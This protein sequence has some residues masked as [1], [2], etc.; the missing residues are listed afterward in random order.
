MQKVGMS[1]KEIKTSIRSQIIKVFFLPL[2]TACIHLTVA[3]PLIKRLLFLFGM[4]DVVLFAEGCIATV[5]VFALIYGIVYG[6]TAKTYYK[7][8]E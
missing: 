1:H 2:V 4:T 8:V 6:V 7:I 5:A 3:F